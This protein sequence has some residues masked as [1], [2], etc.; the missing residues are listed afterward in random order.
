MRNIDWSVLRRPLIILG[1]SLLLSAAMFIGGQ[2]FETQQAQQYRQSL[3]SLRSMHREYKTLVDDIAL[4]D[5]YRGQYTGFLDSGLIGPERRLS[6]IESLESSNQGIR[7]PELK[8]N[9]QPQGGFSRPELKIPRDVIVRGSP[10][11]LD[12]SLLHEGDLF[13]YFDALKG[14]ISTLFSVDSCTIRRLNFDSPMNTKSPNLSS[15][16]RLQWVM[17]DAR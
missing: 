13:E 5:E 8:Y 3:S 6:W 10:M 9:L 15:K 1:V 2:Q 16:C 17:I 12:L 4:I 7:L 14:S 11:D